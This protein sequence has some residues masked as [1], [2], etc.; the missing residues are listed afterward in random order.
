MRWNSDRDHFVVDGCDRARKALRSEIRRQVEAEFAE[1]WTASGWF[2]RWWLRR[3]IRAEV[4]RRLD[5][6]A[7]PGALY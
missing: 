4:A 6:S 5:K 1:A 7:P 2:R 3:K